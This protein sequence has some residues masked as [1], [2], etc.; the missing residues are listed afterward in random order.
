MDNMK[1]MDD[2]SHM[3]HHEDTDGHDP[4]DHHGHDS[5]S[6][7]NHHDMSDMTNMNHMSGM[8]H[9][10][11]A[12]MFKRLFWYSVVLAIPTIALD[13]M[14]A[15]LLGYHVPTTL[16]L[17]LIPAALGTV[18]YFWTGMPFLKG[19]V[20]EFKDRKPGMMVLISLGI[21]V[22]FVASW[23]STVGVIASSL[24][25]WW[26]LALLV[27]IMLAGHWIEMGS[28]MSTSS[29]LDSIAELLPEQAHRAKGSSTED[30]A[31][32]DL[33]TGDE[34]IVRP[35]ETI[36]ADGTIVSGTAGINESMITG[37]SLP[38]TRREGESVV[39]GSISTDSSLRV[40]V[41]KTGDGTALSTIRRLVSQAQNSKTPTQ[42]L[43]DK[44]AGLL[45]WYA[46][47]AAV[48]TA[49]VW[50]GLGQPQNALERVI[51]VLVIAC[52]H[53][54]GLAIPLVVS[55]AMGG[56]AAKGVLITK[57]E[58]L[59]TLQ[60]VST[61]V[62]DKT[63]T[64]T[65]G[66]PHV[67]S[68]TP[69]GST[70]LGSEDRVLELAAAAEQESEHPLA[71]AILTEATERDGSVPT[72]T[73][74]HSTPGVGVSATVTEENAAAAHVEVGGPELLKE[75]KLEAPDLEPI[76]AHASATTLYVLKND[77]IVGA[78]DIADQIRP[79]SKQA[80]AALVARGV[81]PVMLTGDSER[82]AASVASELGIKKYYAQVRPEEKDAVIAS[83]QKEQAAGA[84]VAMV[85]DGVNDA[86][87]LARA[88][89]GIAIGAGTDVAIDS[90]D[91]VLTGSDP[92]AVARAIEISRRT[93]R[94][95]HQNLWWAAGYNL[96]SVPLA[97]GI[98]AP[99]GFTLPMSVGALLM[100]AST[101]IV[102]IN[103]RL[104]K[105]QLSRV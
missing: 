78:I 101:V 79:E 68:V 51:T 95:M 5:M 59:E 83:L 2:M 92:A 18:M 28:V 54:L 82:V 30:V 24:S 97:A 12:T 39:A 9:M 94:K 71:R 46:T 93:T 89:V 105:R 74:F 77:T 4:T 8:N 103:A 58:A 44:A 35:G 85:G 104:L 99:V 20:S 56:A 81:T 76:A 67:V 16:P 100:A 27:V 55:I 22:A 7:M 80:V 19:A 38:V 69:L 87:A 34:V 53:A 49:V 3:G 42:L 61:V 40:R 63:G 32:S 36:P 1:N 25:F 37:E 86:P 64:L 31:I 65:L 23:L 50:L 17:T 41:E 21:T 57:R 96:I 10:N 84:G 52:P 102:V 66:T 70:P 6:D 14:F 75:K 91:V 48:I 15:H 60:N 43:A 33:H 29:A 62:F 88:D 45:F 13:P 47:I 11:H 26:E 98:L 72:A 90:A 73:D